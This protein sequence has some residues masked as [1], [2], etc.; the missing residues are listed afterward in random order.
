MR[1]ATLALTLAGALCASPAQGSEGGAS[2]YLLGS[3]GPGAAVL[4]PVE[5]V[6]FD[7]T[8]YWYD[9]S[10]E[11]T[12]EFVIGGNVVLGLDAT[13]AADFATVL[14]VPSTDVLGGTFAIG[15]ALPLGVPDVTASAVLT[16]PGG[17]TSGVSREDSAFVIGDP[18]VTAELG[19][20]VGGNSHVALSTMINVPIGQYREDQ[21]ANLAFHRW[22]V[23]TSLAVTWHDP[24]AGWDISGKAGVTFNGTND[25]TDYKTGTEAHFEASVER[26]FSPKFSAGLQAYRFEQ[27]S[28]DSGSGAVLGP[29]E[30]RVTGLGATAAYNFPIGKMP[31]TARVRV[32]E[33]FDAVRR[34]EG[35]SVMLS[36]T[37]PLSMKLPAGAE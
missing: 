20:N 33:E 26:I 24:A 30:G 17:G 3:G 25:Y 8:F 4:P 1:S 16:G 27:L 28:G 35:T 18:I 10:A 13:I 6:F 31:A 23:D 36:L 22:A 34:L 21:L 12:R 11:A 15:A 37:V 14:W 5:G 19:W 7:N 29:N 2:L 9:G 32:F